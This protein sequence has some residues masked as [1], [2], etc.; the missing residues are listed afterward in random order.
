[1]KTTMLVA[2]ILLGLASAEA[3]AQAQWKTCA[4]EG[5]VCRFS[6]EREVA[7]GAG[8]RYKYRVFRNGAACNT[9]QFGDPA[10]G[11][12]KSCFYDAS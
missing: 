3:A 1:M 7:F 11:V 10:P 4:R 6:G 2:A 8:K 12:K 9:D 5:E